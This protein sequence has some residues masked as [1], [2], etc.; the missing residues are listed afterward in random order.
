MTRQDIRNV[1][2]IAHVDHGK[3]TLVDQLLRQSGQ[4]RTGELKGECI[5]DSNPLERERG[6]TILAKN[7]AIQYTDRDGHDYHINIVDTPGHADF[8]GE[9]ERVLKMADGVLLLVDAAEGTMPQTRYVLSKAL[10][11]GLK[12]I[13]V[14]NKIDRPDARPQV[15]LNQVFD[16]LVE[17]GAHDHA[18]DFP[19][20]YAS[21]RAGWAVDDLDKIPADN[22]GDIHALFD[23]IINHVPVPELDPAAP[24][25]ML[26][27]TI[28]YSDYVGRIGVGR[29]F[30]G[31]IHA[32]QEIITIDRH[33][34]QFK[35]KV[36]QLFQFDGLGRR[37]VDQIGAGDICAVVGL[38]RVDIGDTL[39]DV[40]NPVALD[41]V[42]V[43]EPTLHMSFRINDGPLAG[44]EG[45]Y[46]TSRHLR[47]RLEKELQSNVALRVSFGESNDVEFDVAGRG[48]MHL[49]ILLENMRREGFELCVGKP[50]V[51]YKQEH[52]QWME[53][54]EML[55]IDVPT[56]MIGPAMQ[57]LGD[58]RAE[59]IKMETAGPR[60]QMDFTIP[61]RGLIGLRTRMLTATKGEAIMHHRFHRYVERAGDIPGRKNGVMIAT[62]TGQVTAWALDQL[63]DRGSM[64]VEPG[65]QVY[66]GQVIGEHCK[67]NDITVNIAKLKKLSNMRSSGKDTTVVLKP[68]RKMSLEAAL[69]YIEDDELVEIT[70][71]SI[72]IRKRGLTEADRKR[73]TRKLAASAAE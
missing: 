34:E 43:D 5:L 51:I 39:C 22:T 55:V 66:V 46:V 67:D 60:T 12:P 26:V 24:L 53:P 20:I 57:L 10:H 21:G 35:Q 69:E 48:L 33:G 59:L 45:K 40:E 28:D 52:G 58:R 23:A 25:Q 42:L 73:S 36:S 72:R 4:F 56:D 16:L 71:Q 30:A 64:F 13:V 61:A 70:P 50:T 32:G 31:T 17:L 19:V 3:T 7:C 6:I 29:V 27:T 41:A 65:D 68:A 14:I 38:A 47:E 15:I 44:K 49:G 2:I 9:V 37:E 62:E 63:A 54:A 11:N 18:E 8:S 1:A